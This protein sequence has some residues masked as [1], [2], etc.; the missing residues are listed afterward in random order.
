VRSDS[1]HR[2]N[3]QRLAGSSCKWGKLSASFVPCRFPLLSLSPPALSK[4][5]FIS[6][7]GNVVAWM[8][9]KDGEIWFGVWWAWQWNSMFSDA[10][11]PEAPKNAK[12][13]LYMQQNLCCD[14]SHY[15]RSMPPHPCHVLLSLLH[16]AYLG[17]N[18]RQSNLLMRDFP[19][20]DFGMN[21]HFFYNLSFN[22]EG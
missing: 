4:V 9:D 18:N 22:H 15:V 19:N 10:D 12:R 3:V 7:S 8:Q 2:Q 11:G 13:T 1:I 6:S 5:D 21:G 14:G 20:R 16:S 17:K